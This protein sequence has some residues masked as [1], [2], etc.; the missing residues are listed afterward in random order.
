MS[1]PLR[2]HEFVSNSDGKRRRTLPIVLA[3]QAC[4]IYIFSTAVQSRRRFW[5]MTRSRRIPSRTSF[6]G[7]PLAHN[8]GAIGQCPAQ[9]TSQPTDALGPA[10]FSVQAAENEQAKEDACVIA[11]AGAFPCPR[12]QCLGCTT[13]RIKEQPR[14]GGAQCDNPKLVCL[15][16]GRPPA[17][18]VTSICLAA[19]APPQRQ[20]VRWTCR[21]SEGETF[22]SSGIALGRPAYSSSTRRYVP[23]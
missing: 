15:F 13:A 19:S 1:R 17:R 2:F 8:C 6:D 10:A 20:A 16:A 14:A 22:W 23:V 21:P 5:V 3:K 18:F 4:S 11:S 9:S 7:T 12:Y